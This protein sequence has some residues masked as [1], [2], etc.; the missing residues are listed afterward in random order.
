MNELPWAFFL[1]FFVRT[2]SW[3]ADRVEHP[4]HWKWLIWLEF[5]TKTFKRLKTDAFS[6]EQSISSWSQISWLAMDFKDLCDFLTF[7]QSKKSSIFS[8]TSGVTTL[9]LQKFASRKKFCLERLWNLRVFPTVPWYCPYLRRCSWVSHLKGIETSKIAITSTTTTSP[10]F[11]GQCSS[12]PFVRTASGFFK[13]VVFFVKGKKLPKNPREQDATILPSSLLQFVLT[14]SK[15]P[16]LAIVFHRESRFAHLRASL[17]RHSNQ[18]VQYRWSYPPAANEH[19]MGSAPFRESDIPKTRTNWPDKSNYQPR[20]DHRFCS[21]WQLKA[22]ENL[23]RKN[24]NEK[25][26]IHTSPSQPS[27]MKQRKG[28]A[29]RRPRWTLAFVHPQTE[30]LKNEAKNIYTPWKTSWEP[31]PASSS[32]ILSPKWHENLAWTGKRRFQSTVDQWNT[33]ILAAMKRRTSEADKM[34]FTNNRLEADYCRRSKIMQLL[35]CVLCITEDR[36][37]HWLNK[38]PCDAWKSTAVNEKKHHMLS[39]HQGHFPLDKTSA[40]VREHASSSSLPRLKLHSK[41]AKSSKNTNTHLQNSNRKLSS[42]PQSKGCWTLVVESGWVVET[43]FV[44]QIQGKKLHRLSQLRKLRELLQWELSIFLKSVQH[45][46]QE[47]IWKIL[48]GGLFF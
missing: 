21:T 26:R 8:R 13:C 47:P 18:K 1:F 7:Q 5:K 28:K 23:G 36:K 2:L 27:K 24:S 32:S 34:Q 9:E 37:S 3:R 30:D 25:L 31:Q 12:T 45:D 48:N 16:A 4:K 39:K 41:L 17:F 35:F 19:P 10:S 42:S 6:F 43:G 44:P 33:Q 22:G 20:N 40:I 14:F 15:R 38:T 29:I 46:V 11:P